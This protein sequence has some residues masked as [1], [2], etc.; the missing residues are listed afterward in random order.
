MANCTY[1]VPDL[2]TSGD[3][4]YGPRIC[5]QPFIDWVWSTHGFNGTYWQGG[6]GF[7]DCC[8]NTKPLCR[9]F[10]AFWLLSYSADDYN[11][12]DWSNNILHWGRRYVREQLHALNDL[13]AMCGDGS[14]TA[15]TFNSGCAHYKQVTSSSCDDWDKNCCDWIPCSWVCGAITWICRAWVTITSAVCDLFVPGRLELYLGYFYNEDVV[16]RAGT[17]VHESRHVGGKPH[18]ANFPRGSVF[19]AGKSG[20]DSDWG[21]QGAWMYDALYLWWFYAAGTRTTP[22]IQQAAKQRGNL[23]IDNAFAT[24]PGFNIT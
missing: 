22:A 1:S 12:E 11:N 13:R 3:A 19:G 15:T 18:N 9:V 17:L 21:Y 23:I 6:W 16:S 8:N 10:A 7:D 5:N 2:T 4:L 14:A 20:A 24:H